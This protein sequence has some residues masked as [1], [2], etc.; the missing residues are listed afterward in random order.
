M[1]LGLSIAINTAAVDGIIANLGEMDALIAEAC[2][3]DIDDFSAQVVPI[4]TGF[5]YSSRTK[6][7]EG[8]RWWNRY[9]AGYAAFVELGTR[10]MRAQPYLRLALVAV[11][12]IGNVVKA[13]KAIG[14]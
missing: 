11:D 5:L 6:Q 14:L 4:D 12:Y 10:F 3:E 8:N 7:V 1:G 2:A 9:L 13:A